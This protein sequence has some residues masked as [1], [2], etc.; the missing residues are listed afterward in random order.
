MSKFLV[1]GGAGFIGSN[2]TEHLLHEGHFVRVLD[3]FTSG[4]EENLK[5]TENYNKDGAT[6]NRI[7]EWK[8]L[9]ATFPET[10]FTI[11]KIDSLHNNI[12]EKNGF[13]TIKYSSFK[14]LK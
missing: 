4:N 1:T 5:F 3:N 14:G 8:E 12:F 7:E 6:K 10:K 9:M 11:V 13:N 2:I